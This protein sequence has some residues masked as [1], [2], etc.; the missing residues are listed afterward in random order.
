MDNFWKPFFTLFGIG[1]AV[2]FAKSLKSKKPWQ[3][4]VSEMII[5]GFFSVGA[6]ATLVFFP[7]VPAIAVVGVG[8]LLAVL[9]V[10]FGS[11]V[12]ERL[13][14]KYIGSKDGTGL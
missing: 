1:A 12:I 7:T 3:E 11:E 8:S 10:A 2:S 5:T 13:L 14:D 6:G 9:G 4:V